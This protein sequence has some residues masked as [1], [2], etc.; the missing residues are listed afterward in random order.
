MFR[1]S[2]LLLL[3]AACATPSQPFEGHPVLADIQF[4]GN[5]SISRG[6]LL[7]HIATAPTGGF[8]SKTARY[9]DADLFALDLKRIVRWYNEKGFYEAKILDVQ[10][11][12]DDAGRVTVVVKLEEGPRAMVRKMDFAGLEQLDK[13][14]VSDIDDALPIHPGDAFDEDSYEKAKDVLQLQLKERGFAE[15][16]VGGKVEI[17]EDVEAHITFLCQTGSRFQFGKVM[18][19]G[20]RQVPAEEIAFATGINRG[21]R[22]SPTALQLAQQRVYNLGAFSGV[23]VGLEPL[24]NSPFAAIRVNVRE[25]PFQTVRFGVGA[26]TE[27]TRWELPRLRAE[28]TNRSLFGG[29]RRLE[30][31]TTV[32]YAFVTSPFSYD[33]AHSGLTSSSSAQ[34]VVPSVILPGLDFITR[35]EFRREVQGG[36]SYDQVAARVS[37]LYRRGRHTVSPSLNF[38]RYFLIDLGVTSI[39]SLVARTGPSAGLFTD[40]PVSCTLTYPELRYTYDARDNAIEPSS[41]IYFSAGVQQTLKPGSFKYFRMDPEIRFYNPA[42]RYAIFA[43]RVHYGGM[44]PEGGS[45]TPFTQRFFYGGQNEQRGYAPLRQGPKLGIQPVCDATKDPSCP[46]S[47]ARGSLPVGAKAALLFTAELRIHADWLLNHLGI[48]PFV[49]A[50]QVGDDWRNPMGSTSYRSSFGLEFSPGIGLRYITPFGPLRFDIAWVLNPKDI[51]TIS[52]SDQ[53]LPTRVS[54][55]CGG[56]DTTCIHESRYAFHLTL[57]EAF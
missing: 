29:L 28:Y 41:G 53:I 43:V 8:F 2:A 26:Q 16:T 5:K 25:A 20:N 35:G 9:Y 17:A 18:V 42:S 12:R 1:L 52:S 46:P 11:L 7:Q 57:G 56:A 24:G 10:E 45:A 51:T 31:Q 30:L 49:D 13:G 6:E 54:V 4:Q 44:I 21:D 32:G 36:Y 37:L 38:V 34:M 48:V 33:P 19:Q 47:Y 15:A 40:C 55:H 27:D 3:A 23:R 14:E 50:S 22:Y 39:E